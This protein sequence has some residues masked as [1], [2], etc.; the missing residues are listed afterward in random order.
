VTGG[1]GGRDA[2]GSDEWKL[3]KGRGA[4]GTAAGSSEAPGSENLCLML[5]IFKNN[6]Y[7][8]FTM[9]IFTMCLGFRV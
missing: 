7:S 2:K 6:V 3:R 5:S 1:Y 8:I 9:C 4:G